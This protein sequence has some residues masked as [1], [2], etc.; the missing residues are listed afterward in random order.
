MD[1]E[2]RFWGERQRLAILVS[3]QDHC[4]VDLLWRWRRGELDAEVG[5]A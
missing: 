5:R 4:L 2:M 1:W 3:R